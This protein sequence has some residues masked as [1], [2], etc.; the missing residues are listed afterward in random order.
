MHG[1]MVL[2]Y[3]YEVLLLKE[4]EY[5]NSFADKTNLKQ[6]NLSK[7]IFMKIDIRITNECPYKKGSTTWL[8]VIWM[9][10]LNKSMCA[11]P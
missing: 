10:N 4:S 11:L 8:P 5:Q 9:S 3:H 7:Y 6:T 1:D 2:S